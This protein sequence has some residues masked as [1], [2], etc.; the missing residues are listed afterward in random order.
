VSA[1]APKAS[2][3]LPGKD[4]LATMIL[5]SAPRLFRHVRFS[6]LVWLVF[7]ALLN[8]FDLITT[9][10]DLRAGMR[11]GNPL[12]RALLD[13]GG[14]SALIGYKVLMV[15]AV[16]AGILALSRSYPLLART[17][18]AVCNALVLTVVLSNFIQYQL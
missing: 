7:F 10:V 16:S 18:L 11:E 17:A 4:C 14:F 8:G 5:H 15:L 2:P 12:M 3:G 6:S 9:Y 1:S 13:Q